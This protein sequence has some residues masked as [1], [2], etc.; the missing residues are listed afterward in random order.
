MMP[1]D[2]FIY[3]GLIGVYLLILFY[4]KIIN[5]FG[6]SIPLVVACVAGGIYEAP[7][8]IMIYFVF[9]KLNEN[10]KA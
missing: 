3:F 6:W 7:M 9:L 5:K 10:V 4:L 1:L 2:I 8:E